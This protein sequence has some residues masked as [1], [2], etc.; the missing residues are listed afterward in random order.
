MA[1]STLD[2]PTTTDRP[3]SAP[4][5]CYIN[6]LGCLPSARKS[7]QASP[8]FVVRPDKLDAG[9]TT[10]LMAA[11]E[12]MLA[13]KLGSLVD[14]LQPIREALAIR[15][16]EVDHHEPSRYGAAVGFLD[17]LNNMLREYAQDFDLVPYCEKYLAKQEAEQQ[18][19]AEKDA[20]KEAFAAR[21]RKARESKKRQVARAN[22]L[23]AA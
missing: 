11:T 8:A 3:N 21:M 15:D 9:K 20:K 5:Y 13:I 17:T 2:Q 7:G 4:R 6:P 22:R 16:D 10:G 12:Y 19:A 14:Q 23:A 1:S 18:Q